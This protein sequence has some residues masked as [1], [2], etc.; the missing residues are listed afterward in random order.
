MATL[1]SY[2]YEDI[3]REMEDIVLEDWISVEIF[4]AANNYVMGY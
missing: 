1:S 3:M 2:T 4:K